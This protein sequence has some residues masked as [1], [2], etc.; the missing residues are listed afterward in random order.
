IEADRRYDELLRSVF[1]DTLVVER[2]QDA[3]PL[4]GR[5][6]MV[7]LDGDVLERHGLM[8]GGTATRGSQ[9]LVAAAHA[10]AEVEEKKRGLQELDKQRSAARAALQKAEAEWA[11]ASEQLSREQ[12]A[13]AEVEG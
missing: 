4:I 7:T 9:L 1:T 13:L 2:L 8:T 10:A 5:Y 6:R 3:L 12:A 11:Q